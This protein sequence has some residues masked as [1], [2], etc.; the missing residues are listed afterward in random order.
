MKIT[1]S[2]YPRPGMGGFALFHRGQIDQM[3]EQG[4]GLIKAQYNYNYK[5][6]KKGPNW[7]Q[8]FYEQKEDTFRFVTEKE[9]SMAFVT[10]TNEDFGEVVLLIEKDF[11]KGTMLISE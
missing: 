7:G 9:G 5:F 3:L 6:V 10:L 2:T 11:A 8:A 1:T 4:Y